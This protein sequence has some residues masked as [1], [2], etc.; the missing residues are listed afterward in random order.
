M[1]QV[2]KAI[3]P[4][5]SDEVIEV[6]GVSE[7][8]IESVEILENP[9][10]DS[11]IE[12]DTPEIVNEETTNVEEFKNGGIVKASAGSELTDEYR[13]KALRRAQILTDTHFADTLG[14]IYGQY[15]DTKEFVNKT[16]D[17]LAKR[18]HVAPKVQYDRFVTFADRNY[19][20]IGS[21]LLTNIGTI[22]VSDSGQNL[23][24]KLSGFKQYGDLMKEKY[25]KLSLNWDDYQ[26]KWTATKQQ[27]NIYNAEKA[28]K[29]N[30]YAVNAEVMRLKGLHAAKDTA[31]LQGTNAISNKTHEEWNRLT[32]IGKQKSANEWRAMRYE[33]LAAAAKDEETKNAYLN[34]AKQMRSPELE[35]LMLNQQGYYI[36]QFVKRGGRIRPLSHQMLIDRQKMVAKAVQKLSDDTMKLILKALS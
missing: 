8:G 30:E 11:A 36:P 3:R 26:K 31:R 22:N 21:K 5:K 15:Y 16:A 13:N 6:T 23:A 7:N 34:L 1:A 20:D 14:N 10:E 4:S 2:K 12:I 9:I 19:D 24:A 28:N 35:Q 25:G 17:V 18:K 32:T 33:E 29:D 27:E